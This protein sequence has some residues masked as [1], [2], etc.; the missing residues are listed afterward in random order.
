MYI[1]ILA[2]TLFLLGTIVFY[3][4]SLGIS[5][6]PTSSTVRK[7]LFANLPLNLEGRI[8][9]LGSG[10]GHIAYR[11]AKRYPNAIVIGYEKSIVPYFVSKCFRRSN[12]T[13]I[14]KDLQEADLEKPSLIYCYLF[15]GAM[16]Q[17]AKKKRNGVLISNSFALPNI[18][19]S[20][21]IIVHDLSRSCL[22]KYDWSLLACSWN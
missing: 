1:L 8:Y 15:P 5:P 14:R 20:R 22:F 13:F 2:I 19:P 17:I 18:K 4:I 7:A 12:L 9:E 11:L 6:M 3:S 16:E 21:K 10:W